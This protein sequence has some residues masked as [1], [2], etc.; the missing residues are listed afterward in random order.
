MAQGINVKLRSIRLNDRALEFQIPDPG[1][2]KSK[3]H[4]RRFTHEKLEDENFGNGLGCSG[5]G[6]DDGFRGWCCG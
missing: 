1:I 3:T 4:N 6:V 2:K 5:Y